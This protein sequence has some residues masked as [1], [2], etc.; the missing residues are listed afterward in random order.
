MTTV[1]VHKRSPRRTRVEGIL[2]WAVLVFCATG[3]AALAQEPPR[4][5]LNAGAM[6]PGAIGSQRLHRGGPL[7][8]Y[9][10][11]VKIRAPEGARISLA[12]EEGFSEGASNNMLVGL[13]IGPVYRLRVVDAAN[14]EGM[15]IFPTLEVIDRTYPPSKLALR[16]PIPIEL[17]QDEMELA[18]HGAFVTR[19]IYVEDP[20]QSLPIAR[21]AN[22]EQPWFEAPKGEDP[23][24]TADRHG[25]PVA[26]LR[27]GARTPSNHAAECGMATPRFVV[28]PTVIETAAR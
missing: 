1:L 22:G 24:V 11:P 16:Y 26:I 3:H 14:S 19:V 15:D 27:L 20:Q 25:R 4:H 17:T 6:P 7:P 9:F 10:Q 12:T 23:L 5:G 2:R 18:A 21:Q 28:F 13:A 8:G